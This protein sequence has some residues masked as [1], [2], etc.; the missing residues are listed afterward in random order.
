VTESLP[1]DVFL[2]G[3]HAWKIAKVR[4]DRV[5]VEDAQGM[6]P[7]IP[8]WK[9]EHPS[10]SWDLG[11]AVGRLRRDAADRLD[12]PDFGE[13]AAR[14][15]GLDA[16]ASL[17][18]QAWLVKAGEVLQGV[19]DDQGIVVESFSDEMGGRHAMIHSVFGMRING[20]WGMALR[21]QVRRRF[22]LLAE[23]SHVDD[24][25]LLSF[26]PGQVPP[27]PERLVTLVSPEELDPLL[28][29]ALIGTPLFGTRF[30]HCAIRSLYIPR[31][32][33]GQRTPPYLQRLKADALLESV[34][35]Q[36]DFPVVAETLRECFNDAYDVP[37]LKRLLERLHDREMWV[38][39]RGHAAALAV[40]LPAAAGVG[41]GVPRRRP[42]RGAAQRRRGHAQGLERG[43]GPATG[44]D[45]RRRRGRAAEARCPSAA[46]ATPTSWPRCSTT[47]AT[48]RAR[49]SPSASSATPTR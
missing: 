35:G 9:G 23:A 28:G 15:C 13:W 38:R 39:T 5:L 34:R 46:R 42:R 32:T 47:S 25:I 11:V 26:A 7:T 3:S 16:R 8:F 27:A 2:L 31:M 49:R 22:G 43:D 44:R 17:A 21:E 41:L 36:P 12:A 18:M 19:A 33:R 30:R 10:R 6:S 20:A 4:A 48:S 29:E 24:G 1:G 37:K 45:R 40:R 14:E